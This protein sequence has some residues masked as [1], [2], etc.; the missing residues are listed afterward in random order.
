MAIKAANTLLQV[1]TATTTAVT[2]T[3]ATL[4]SPCV[5]TAV[6][7][8]A[9][10]AII[11][12]TSIVGMTQLNGRAFVVASATGTTITLKGIDSTGYTAY[13][14]GGSATPQTMTSVGA[15]KSVQ[16]FNGQ[17]S[18]INT[19]HLQSTAQ[20]F[21]LGLQDFGTVDL[22]LFLISDTGQTKLRALKA[23]AAVGYFT[24]TLSDGTV[25]AFAAFVKSFSLDSLT[26]DTA[27]AG[28]ASL[29]VTGEPAW[30]A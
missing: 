16:G 3:A 28:A 18:E 23:L 21:I 27:V 17:S 29:R 30:F 9:A 1:S 15:V 13:V 2:I 26:P 7:S 11:V 20:E 4:A 12:I 19:S 8:L 10:G 24:I 22:G 6:N 5:L 25:A 14:S